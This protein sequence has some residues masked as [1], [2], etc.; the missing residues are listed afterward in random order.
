MAHPALIPYA[1][2][3]A[4]LAALREYPVMRHACEAAGIARSAVHTRQQKDKDFA[5]A[6]EEAME[7]GVDRA[8]KEA[9]RRAV[10]GF[11]E[12]VIHQ[13]RLQFVYERYLD[14]EGK[15]QY[16][17]LLDANGQPI[18]LTVRKHSDA[19]LGLVL[20]ARRKSYGT[21]RTEL[22]SPDGSMS[23]VDETSRA[24]RVAQLLAAARERKA[25][26]DSFDDL[27]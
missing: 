22:T 3:E 9:M 13:G 1:W 2:T 4:F 24:A 18:P 16:R 15:E 17:M 7:E 10:V 8:E 25:A 14:A 27:A 11:E 23:P 19:L 12:P 20:K 6:V 5:K 26:E 21:E